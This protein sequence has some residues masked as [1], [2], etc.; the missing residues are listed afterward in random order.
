VVLAPLVACH[1]GL[2]TLLQY[3]GKKT[4]LILTVTCFKSF[5]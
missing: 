5:D 1:Q 2:Y 3:E 4:S